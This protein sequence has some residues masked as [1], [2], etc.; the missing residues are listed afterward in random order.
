MRQIL[1]LSAL[2]LLAACN[3]QDGDAQDPTARKQD[4]AGNNFAAITEQETLRFT[5]TEPFWGGSVTGKTLTW[6]TPDNPEG[7][8]IPVQ[9]FTGNNGL[10]FSGK[11]DASDFNMA[12]TH[13][14]CS[15]GMSDRVYP[16]TVTVEISQAPQSGCGW[17]EKMPF[18]G[19]EQP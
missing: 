13:A 1:A 9:R 8:T 17:T 18:T 2:A 5:G 19:P 3:S 11:L 14:P 6:T 15:D 10:G 4:G 16:F 12:V 7:S